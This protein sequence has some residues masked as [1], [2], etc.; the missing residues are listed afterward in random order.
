MPS[1]NLSRNQWSFT[2]LKWTFGVL[3]AILIAW[4]VYCNISTLALLAI[5]F[6]LSY[7]LDPVVTHLQRKG[8]S[9]TWAI[10]FLFTFMA[11]AL[12]FLALILT[13]QITHQAK[14]FFLESPRGDLPHSTL[15]PTNP[16][17]PSPAAPEP[18]NHFIAWFEETVNPFLTNLGIESLG[19][20]DLRARIQQ[21][22]R[23]IDSHFPQW[24][25][26]VLNVFQSMFTG[27]ANFI[28]GILNLLLVPVFTFYLLRDYPMIGKSFYAIIPPQWREPAADWMKELDQ[29]VG[30]FIRGQF[31]IAL[32][33]ALVNAIGLTVIGVPFGFLVGV[34]AGLANMVP[35]MSIIVGLIPAMLLSFLDRPDVWRLLWVIAI[36][37]GAQ[38]LE[39]FYL[40]P[41]IMGREIGLHP[42][43]IMLAIIVGG[44]LFG[45]VGII[46]AAPIAAM[47]KVLLVR[48]H[49]SWKEQWPV[50]D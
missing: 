35:Y 3:G 11:A 34:I 13:P 5:S 46:L 2:A 31:S 25:Q 45:L 18:A 47:L 39:G 26:S 19:R 1:N 7:L 32:I 23:W 10:S 16:S 9:R 24:S 21:L 28:V 15:S 17:N 40:S 14:A 33:L 37:C 22:Y 38:M 20:D 30:G 50:S 6:L 49:T 29:V 44:S 41:R 27:V 48:C 43:L 8:L 4:A 36:F 12:V 42:V